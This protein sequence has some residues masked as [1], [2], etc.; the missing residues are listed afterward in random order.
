MPSWTPAIFEFGLPGVSAASSRF[1]ADH[2]VA[3]GNA[4]KDNFANSRRVKDNTPEK[5]D[6]LLVLRAKT[7][8]W[9]LRRFMDAV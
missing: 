7:E 8:P 9:F 2:S 1:I 3:P 4:A 5:E 6:L